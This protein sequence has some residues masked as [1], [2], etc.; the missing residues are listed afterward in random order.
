MSRPT[1][2]KLSDGER[3]GSSKLHV[4]FLA[5]EPERARVD[6]RVLLAG[7]EQLGVR[8]EDHRRVDAEALGEASLGA[9]GQPPQS[10][11]RGP[12]QHVAGVAAS[13]DVGAAELL[14][15]GDEIGHRQLVDLAEVDAAQQREV[16]RLGLLGG[17]DG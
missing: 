9:L 1:T 4:A 14:E 15:R 17:H 16:Q 11:G 12:K 10:R 5:D 7:G 8:A 13:A 3:L 6:E 2:T